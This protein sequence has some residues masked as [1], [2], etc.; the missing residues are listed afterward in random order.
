MSD[1]GK[2]KSLAGYPRR[3][4]SSTRYDGKDLMLEDGDLVLRRMPLEERID[5]V[6]DEVSQ[7]LTSVLDVRTNGHDIEIDYQPFGYETH[8]LRVDVCVA[9]FAV[10]QGDLPYQPDYRCSVIA[11]APYVERRRRWLVR[12]PVPA[13]R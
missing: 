11:F 9:A 13:H 8:V 10:H 4:D 7:Y 2:L 3:F 5:A 12:G 6:F 1:A